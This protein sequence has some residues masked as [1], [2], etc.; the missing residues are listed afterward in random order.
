M[1]AWGKVSV[2]VI[3]LAALALCSPVVFAQDKD[4]RVT[5]PKNPLPPI[6]GEESSSKN[7]VGKTGTE[8][9]QKQGSVPLTSVQEWSPGGS[10]AGQNIL[11]GSFYASFGADS[12]SGSGNSKLNQTATVSGN[13]GIQRTWKNSNA[14]ARYSGGGTFYP[15]ANARN[16]TDHDLYVSFDKS[17]RKW[18]FL[19]ANST[20]YSPEGILGYYSGSYGRGGNGLNNLVSPGQQIASVN[21]SRVSNHVVGEFRYSFNAQAGMTFGGSY[22]LTRFIDNGLIDSNVI[23]FRAGYNRAISSRDWLAVNYNGRIFRYMSLPNENLNNTVQ[24]VYG[25]ML[26]GRLTFNIGAGP[27]FSRNNPGTGLPVSNRVSW[28]MQSSLGYALDGSSLSFSYFHAETDGSGYFLG[29]DSDGVNVN[30]AT[31]FARNWQLGVTASYS[32]NEA[33]GSS[34]VTNLPVGTRFNGWGGGVSLSRPIRRTMNVFF[35]YSAFRQTSSSIACTAPTC[36]LQGTRH[37]F[38]VGFSFHPGPIALD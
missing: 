17:F 33:L 16:R 20:N 36:A 19:A 18:G 24:L 3:W 25:K 14:G 6:G 32:R 2:A 23:G 31:R 21:S 22:G 38:G 29:S 1:K 15:E 37:A 30:Y 9:G 10:G 27:Q 26:T 28:T 4:P 12:F 7:P 35:R 8:G 5:T 34:L 13:L 11:S